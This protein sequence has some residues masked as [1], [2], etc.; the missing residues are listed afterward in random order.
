MAKAIL[1]VGF[2]L[3][4]ND[5]HYEGFR[6]KV[7]LLDWDVV[8][9]RPLI[10]D[11]WGSYVDTYLG[12]PSLDDS[13]SFQL[14]ECCEHW[15]REIKQA[16]EAGKTVIVFLPQVQDIYIATGE[17]QYSGTGRNQKTTRIVTQYTNY[18]AL[19]IS[20]KPI[21]ATGS[22]MKLAPLGAEI[23]APYWAE[24]ADASEY[25]VLLS[26]DTPDVCI[27]TK[28]GDKP[29]AALVRSKTSTGSLILLP[30]ID[31]YPENF[32]KQQAKGQVWTAAAKQFSGRFIGAIVALDKA[33]RTSAEVTPEPGWA[34]SDL[35]ALSAERTL[36]SELLEAERRVE[37]AQQTKELVQEQLSS[38][39]KLRS[40][41]FEKGKPL[42]YAIVDALNT[43]GFEA[44][45]Y[46]DTESE[47]D[48]VFQCPEGRLLGEAEGKDNKAI[49]VD[50]LRQL[51]MNI[52]EDLQRD[53]VMLPAKGVLFG[54]GFRLSVPA[55]RETQFTEK[56]ISAAQSSSTALI[57]TTELFKAV[58]YLAEQSDEA[59]SA[60]CRQAI[61]VGVGVVALPTPPIQT[62]VAPEVESEPEVL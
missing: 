45:Q 37:E 47:F 21:N 60:E 61:L 59:Y 30:N 25:M 15:R 54:N 62:L 58:Q 24:F 34:S 20:L 39:G 22:A 56:C 48:V 43:L 29:V 27:T 55:E 14:K 40:L 32:Y 7:S 6:S 2:E 26:A 44:A 46:K 28:N 57:P 16:I 35:Y 19:P 12:K 33:L 8:L 49:N 4:S 36:R 51:A 11:F 38:A 50:K 1:T 17:R 9:F 42:E 31:F 53:D 41:L 5:T 23:L 10:D 18:A 13:A 52:H 3:A